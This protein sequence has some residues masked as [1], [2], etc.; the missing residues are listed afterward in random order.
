VWLH[1]NN[2]ASRISKYIYKHK[3]I[4][5]NISHEKNLWD[6]L[7]VH[8]LHDTLKFIIKP[9]HKFNIR[10]FK[11]IFILT[12]SSQSVKNIIYRPCNI[13][14]LNCPHAWQPFFQSIRNKSHAHLK[15]PP[16]NLLIIRKIT[17]S[18]ISYL[19]VNYNTGFSRRIIIFIN[20][21]IYFVRCFIKTI[22]INPLFTPSA[23][24]DKEIVKALNFHMLK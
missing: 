8:L 4:A 21:F 3:F 22:K 10:I 18:R 15:I 16:H 20:K 14:T 1:K 19:P 13:F 9:A 7:T 24:R 5:D 23:K 17:F 11:H 6:I 12:A 2:I